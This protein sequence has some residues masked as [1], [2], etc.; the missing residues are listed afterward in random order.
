MPMSEFSASSD[1]E[2]AAVVLAGG[3]GTRIRHLLPGLPKPMAQVAGR[4]F[5]EH[6]LFHLAA[7][8][9]QAAVLSTGHLS[10]VIERHFVPGRV[11]GLA[12]S[13]VREDE[14]RGTA[15]GFLL[16]VK[17]SGLHPDVWLVANGDS[18]VYADL[19]PFLR[20]FAVGGW[21]AAVLG[22]Q[23]DDAA[24]Y[25][26]L[27]ADARG[28]L[29]R[30]AEKRPGAALINA[31]VY[32]FRAGLLGEFPVKTPLSFETEV[33]PA[34]LSAGRHILVH[35]VSAPFLDIGTPASLAQAGEFISVH[36]GQ[37]GGG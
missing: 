20:E 27:E 18:L 28:G 16:A 33:F 13:C 24:R 26:T 2:V 25:G 1:G 37:T 7:Q 6:V 9:I 29:L 8:G 32:L 36:G 14:P 10:E 34:L 22:L 19:R 4:P 21:D 35:P 17:A 5:L 23:V 30:F 31:G 11:R 12:V 3:L 15:G